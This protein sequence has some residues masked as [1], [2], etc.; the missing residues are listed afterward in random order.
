MLLGP[1]QRFLYFLRISDRPMRNR[2]HDNWNQNDGSIGPNFFSETSTRMLFA[3]GDLAAASDAFDAFKLNHAIML[4]CGMKRVNAACVK[5][6]QL[7]Q[8]RADTG[9]GPYIQ[10][11]HLL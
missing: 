11:H 8:F 5:Q 10:P 3:Q 6:N 2:E 9:I 1:G 4:S 7:S